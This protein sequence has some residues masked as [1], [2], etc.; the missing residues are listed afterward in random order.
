[1]SNTRRLWTPGSSADLVMPGQF[2]SGARRP[3]FE[4]INLSELGILPGVA[5]GAQGTHV[6]SDVVTQTADGRDLNVVWTDMLALLNAANGSRQALIRFLTFGVTNPVEMVAQAGTGVDFEDASEFGEPVGARIQPTYFNMGYPF[7]WYDLAGRYTWQYLADATT[8]MIDSVANAAVEAYWRKQMFEVLK[9]VFNPTNLSATINQAAYNVYKFYN[10]DGV[11][12]PTYKTN[13]F[14]NTHTHYRTTGASALVAGDLDEMIADLNA[15]GYSQENGYR[16]VLMV[17]TTQGNVIRGFR[18]VANGG[19]GVYDFI[20]A[21]GQPGQI[22]AQTTTVI[23]QSQIGNSLDG[24]QV[25]G[26]YGPLIVVQD[27]WLP[28]T[29]IFGFATGGSESLANPV[30][31]REHAQAGLRGLRLVKGRTPD[32]PLIDSFWAFGFGTGVR[33]RGAGFVMEITTDG[34]YD[35]PSVYA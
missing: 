17:H 33:H 18:S 25:I 14:D 13:T 19:T 24:L 28:S 10:A 27:D 2:G 3:G 31:I 35:P 26:N 20:P 32:Y 4:R 11:V 7:K 5:G 22:T 34:S 6:N 23:G 16:Q 15:H 30:G 1:M 21:Q 29:H 12:P 9:T 8:T